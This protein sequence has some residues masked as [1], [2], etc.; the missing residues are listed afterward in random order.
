[1][2]VENGEGKIQAEYAPSLTDTKRK[3]RCS[4]VCICCD[5]GCC[6]TTI[7]LNPEMAKITQVF[8]VSWY[9]GTFIFHE[10]QYQ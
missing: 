6:Q 2:M 5:L 10:A 9:K 8:K 4:N 1:M 7:N 3:R